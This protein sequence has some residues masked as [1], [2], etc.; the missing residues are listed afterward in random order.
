MAGSGVNLNKA[1]G[2]W[3]FNTLVDEL[4]KSRASFEG[5]LIFLQCSQSGVPSCL[6]LGV[7]W[8]LSGQ[9]QMKSLLTYLNIWNGQEFII[10]P[11]GFDL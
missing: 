6:A 8:Q 1:A 10:S 7:E 4:S 9:T 5:C 3:Q 2:G 11:H